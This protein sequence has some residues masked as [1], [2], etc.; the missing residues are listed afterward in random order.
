M[1]TLRSLA[2]VAMLLCSLVG[3][4]SGQTLLRDSYRLE[5]SQ[6]TLSNTSKGVFEIR[7][8]WVHSV[9]LREQEEGHVFHAAVLHHGKLYKV[10]AACFDE[11]S[12]G[13]IAYVPEEMRGAKVLFVSHDGRSYFG[14]EE[15][16]IEYSEDA[17]RWDQGV[18]VEEG[19]QG[20]ALLRMDTP[21]RM[22]ALD[23]Y[24]QS[25]VWLRTMVAE[26]ATLRREILKERVAPF[27][28]AFM[29]A[30]RGLWATASFGWG[31]AVDNPAM[32]E[33][34]AWQG[35][36]KGA[37]YAWSVEKIFQIF[38]LD[39]TEYWKGHLASST[40]DRRGV[41]S[42]IRRREA[43]LDA[44]TLAMQAE[45][46]ACLQRHYG[47]RMP[48]RFREVGATNPPPLGMAFTPCPT[49][50][51]PAAVQTP[52]QAAAVGTARLPIPPQLEPPP[53]RPQ[54]P[55]LEPP[56]QPPGHP[57]EQARKK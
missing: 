54:P 20:V 28:K 56:P 40:P 14:A 48:A 5:L 43:R 32:F 8:H 3:C 36:W 57:V 53:K 41:L 9:F 1:A 27:A 11:A 30:L 7:G 52:Q 2:L 23:R 24:L 44:N 39:F 26:S 55:R 17:P 38:G 6:Q 19:Q 29:V 47:D 45:Y 15:Y 31:M 25:Q 42:I 10:E 46:K 16:W 33:D 37:N 4:T 50:L 12:D 49:P 34:K 35:V 13:L 18:L 51:P 21:E 22:E